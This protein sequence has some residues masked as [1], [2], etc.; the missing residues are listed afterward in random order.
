MKEEKENKKIIGVDFAAPGADHTVIMTL[1]G[2]QIEITREY[3]DPEICICS[4]VI[5][6]KDGQKILMRGQ[7]H[8]NCIHALADMGAKLLDSPAYQGFITSRGRYV[9]REEGFELQQ[10]AGIQSKDEYR[11]NR[12]FSEDLY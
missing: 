8:H 7:R 11:G 1:K 5:G 2:D 10:K 12:L 6:E 3:K 4:A 9:T